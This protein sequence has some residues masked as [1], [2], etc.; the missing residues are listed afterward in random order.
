MK[1]KAE[2]LREILL[3]VDN[4]AD[5]VHD[6]AKKATEQIIAL[7]KECV[8]EKDH[9]FADNTWDSCRAETLKNIEEMG[10]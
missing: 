3:D 7:F 1:S 2:R 10:K 9:P 4:I 5:F 8:P 6:D